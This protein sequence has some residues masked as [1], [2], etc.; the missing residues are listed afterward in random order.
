MKWLFKLLGQCNAA[1]DIRPTPLILP[2]TILERPFR[3]FQPISPPRGEDP[4]SPPPPPP[5][6]SRIGEYLWTHKYSFEG[7]TTPRETR[8]FFF[9]FF[10]S[11]FLFFTR[12]GEK[13]TRIFI[14]LEFVNTR[15]FAPGNVFI[16]SF[17]ISAKF[18]STRRMIF[19]SKEETRKR[20]KLIFVLKISPDLKGFERKRRVRKI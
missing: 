1:G 13:A 14:S 16:N 7:V 6:C 4:A 10:L 17:V 19:F 12:C 3:I 9:F 2:V 20:M 18:V 5:P 15:L 8:I 11:F